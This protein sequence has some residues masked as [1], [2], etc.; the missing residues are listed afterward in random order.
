MVSFTIRKNGT[1]LPGCTFSGPSTGLH[2]AINEFDKRF[3]HLDTG[4]LE[5]VSSDGKSKMII[6]SKDK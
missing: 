3:R 1:P 2:S 5:L 6:L 4:T